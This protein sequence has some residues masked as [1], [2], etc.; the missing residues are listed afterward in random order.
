MESHGEDSQRNPV[1]QRSKHPG[2]ERAEDLSVRIE[3]LSSKA[4]SCATDKGILVTVE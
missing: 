4:S 2:V 1:V 3:L